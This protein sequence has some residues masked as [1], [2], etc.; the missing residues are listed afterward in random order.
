MVLE[1]LADGGVRQGLTRALSQQLAIQTIIGT[2]IM[3]RDSG[4]NPAQIR[5]RI[6]FSDYMSSKSMKI[7][8]DVS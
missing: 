5:V 4:V 7:T 3:A 6:D 1:A 2:A 8:L